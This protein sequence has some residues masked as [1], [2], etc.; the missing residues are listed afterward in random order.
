MTADVHRPSIAVRCRACWFA[1]ALVTL[2]VAS[3]VSLDLQWAQFFSRDAVAA[4][5]R[6]VGEFFP[7]DTRPAFVKQVV[8][9]TWQTLAMSAL[10]TALAAALGLA[11]A[12]PASRPHPGA[13]GHSPQCRWRSAG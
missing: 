9:A 8:E 10:G 4:M 13:A 3:F 11:L 2:V 12:L 6:F 7:P 1:V 5:T